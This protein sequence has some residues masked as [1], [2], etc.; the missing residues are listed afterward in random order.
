[1]QGTVRII[2]AVCVVLQIT[3]CEAGTTAVISPEQSPAAIEQDVRNFWPYWPAEMRIHPLTRLVIDTD[4]GETVI[5]VR[6]ELLDIDGYTTRGCGQLRI[7]LH[8]ALSGAPGQ[9]MRTWELDLRDP[10][11]NRNRYDD[12]TRTYMFP[13]DTEMQQ[14]PEEPELR[15]YFLSADGQAIRSR[16]LR[17]RTE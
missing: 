8:D 17:L 6:I 14:L 15:A 10:A 16:P 1:M 4:T 13:L 12:V 2:A 9:A 11:V 5:E 7:D 3:G